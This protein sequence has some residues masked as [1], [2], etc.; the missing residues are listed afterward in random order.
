MSKKVFISYSIDSEEHVA[1]VSALVK[2]LRGDGLD[3]TYYEE[4]E[5][6]ER[7]NHFMET[8]IRISDYVLFVCTPNYKLKADGR[9]GGV[10]TETNIITSS[11]FDSADEKKFKPI[12]FDGEWNDALPTWAVDKRGYNLSKID[13]FEQEY[14]RLIKDVKRY[15]SGEPIATAIPHSPKTE[16]RTV[17][18][19]DGTYTGDIVDDKRHGKGKI[20]WSNGDWYDGDWLNDNR[21][22]KGKHNGTNRDGLGY[23]YIGDF[24]VG[25][26]N[27]KG[28]VTWADG[29]W[30]DG[31]WINGKRT[32]KGEYHGTTSD[33]ESYMYLGNYAD[34]KRH[35]KGKITWADGEWYY[36]DWVKGK[37]TGKGEYHFADRSVYVGE[38][39]N[40]NRH[41]VGKH[42][43]FDGRV[44]EG[45]WIN[46]N[47][48]GNEG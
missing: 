10:G 29:S 2:R 27:G 41:G 17:T 22:G 38:F 30:Y 24:V 45:E 40:S 1:K 36:G 28:K 26:W 42:T 9:I 39:E 32:G 33:G 8:H 15:I 4:L 48:F 47:F 34:N 37:R 31:D 44:L 43:F 18:Y 13:V 11:I 21:T 6:G 16:F 19:Y 3:V 35:G 12:L 23:V 20:M 5:G 14:A 25:K 7:I 46:G